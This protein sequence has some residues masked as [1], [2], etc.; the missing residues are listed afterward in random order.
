[1]LFKHEQRMINTVSVLVR[2]KQKMEI[3]LNGGFFVFWWRLV[4]VMR[5]MSS[6]ERPKGVLVV[7]GYCVCKAIENDL[8]PMIHIY[9]KLQF[10]CP[11]NH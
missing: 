9:L 3:H 8:A 6:P 2:H 11:L 1:M 5:S 10:I 7:C 4:R